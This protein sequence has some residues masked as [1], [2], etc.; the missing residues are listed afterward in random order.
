MS[1]IIIS[2]AGAMFGIPLVLMII[3]A[4]LFG[5]VPSFILW[6]GGWIMALGVVA[7]GIGAV[8]AMYGG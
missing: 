5:D 2:I 7:G 4:I 1:R 6:L 3:I 8:M